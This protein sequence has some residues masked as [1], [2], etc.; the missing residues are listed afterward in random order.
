VLQHRGL[1][2]GLP[3]D[4][5]LLVNRLV[6]LRRVFIGEALYA[7]QFDNEHA[8]DEDIGIVFPN[9]LALVSH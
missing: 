7:L 5:F 4:W 2:E 3:Q 9:V 1:S 6:L 8:F